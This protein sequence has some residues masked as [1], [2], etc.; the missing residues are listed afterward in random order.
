VRFE[1]TWKTIWAAAIGMPLCF[2]HP[3]GASTIETFKACWFGVILLSVV[4]PWPPVTDSYFRSTRD[5]RK[6]AQVAT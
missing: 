3:I 1:L 5:R 6:R 2:A 4:I